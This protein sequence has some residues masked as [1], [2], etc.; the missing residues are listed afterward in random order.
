M[1]R[2]TPPHRRAPGR[3]PA[4]GAAPEGQMPKRP[5]PFPRHGATRQ[6]G[7]RAARQWGWICLAG[8][9]VLGGCATTGD[10]K[11]VQGANRVQDRRLAAIEESAARELKK[12]AREIAELKKT[13]KAT[14]GRLFNLTQKARQMADEQTALAEGV[15]KSVARARASTRRVKAQQKSLSAFKTEQKKN[16]D[17]VR[18]QLEQVEKLMKTSI[19]NLPSKTQADRLYRE[20]FTHMVSGELGLAAAKFEK[21][22]KT[23]GKDPRVPDAKYRA[24]QA[25]FLLRK[26]DHAIVPFFQ[27]ADNYAGHRL[28]VDAR[29]MLARSLEETGDL[30][31]ALE[32]YAQLI[33]ENTVHK[34]DATRRVYFIN[35][36]YPNLKKK[37]GPKGAAAQGKSG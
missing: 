14:E 34:A 15:E 20:A 2:E 22:G 10:L 16:L 13:E 12:L 4:S 29:W 9:A 7:W 19:A 3:E 37:H 27:L 35:E 23:Y 24:G 17:A 5:G 1:A 36:L 21:F 28:A 31:L 30:K 32:F 6:W 18:L 33:A 8:L 11:K 25:F 26:Y